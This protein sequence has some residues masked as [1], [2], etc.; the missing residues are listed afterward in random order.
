MTLDGD[1]LYE[2]NEFYVWLLAD[3]DYTQRTV[4]VIDTDTL[5]TLA[6]FPMTIPNSSFGGTCGGHILAD[7]TFEYYR[8][9]LSTALSGTEPEWVQINPKAVEGSE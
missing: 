5:E 9:E 8:G 3:D 7:T 1:R 4:T 2:D 6:T